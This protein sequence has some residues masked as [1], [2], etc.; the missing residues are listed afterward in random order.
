MDLRKIKILFRTAD[1]ALYGIPYDLR[2]GQQPIHL[3]RA[4]QDYV[5]NPGQY[6]SRRIDLSDWLYLGS[7]GW[8]GNLS[9]DDQTA[10]QAFLEGKD[11]PGNPYEWTR[12]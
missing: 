3:W 5:P 11:V 1:L 8:W 7:P 12:V 2:P 10:I 4:H 9:K 6:G